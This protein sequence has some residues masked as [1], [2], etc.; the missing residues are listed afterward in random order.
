MLEE[1]V[2][3]FGSVDILVNNAGAYEYIPLEEITN[4]HFHRL[5]DLNV[6]RTILV[7]QAAPP[8]PRKTGGSVINISSVVS[9]WVC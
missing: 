6:L 8:H 3:G 4:D 9:V 1:A 5:F 2:K 7:T